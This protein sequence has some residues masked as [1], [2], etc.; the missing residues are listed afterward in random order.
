MLCERT[1]KQQTP[2]T[3]KKADLV[4]S[5]T[6]VS[7]TEKIILEINWIT[8]PF[9]PTGICQCKILSH[10]YGQTKL[11]LNYKNNK[12][13]RIHFL[14]FLN[15]IIT[16][17]KYFHYFFTFYIKLCIYDHI[18]W[19]YGVLRWGKYLTTS[20]NGILKTGWEK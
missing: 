9:I 10:F 17:G 14:L 12:P 1:I 3:P 8:F 5:L 2:P 20:R 13:N 19:V 16:I 4:R 15:Y 11:N 18:F 7:Q 6:L